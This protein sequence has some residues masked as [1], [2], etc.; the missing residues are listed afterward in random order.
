[1][2][3]Y[4]R[5]RGAAVRP[6]TFGDS[7]GVAVAL[8]GRTGGCSMQSESQLEA[9]LG[10]STDPARL[11]GFPSLAL[12]GQ[13]VVPYADRTAP[14]RAT[15]S[16]FAEL[17]DDPATD[18]SELASLAMLREALDSLVTLIERVAPFDL[19]ACWSTPIV[20]SGGRVLGTFAMYYDEPKEPTPA[21]IQLT[22]TAT[23][24]AKN[25]IK[26]ARATTK[27]HAR[28]DAAERLAVALQESET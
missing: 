27:L 4:D 16:F 11:A 21:D 25:V 24:L 15:G 13:H 18:D 8:L 6:P 26:R 28:T 5:E 19:V 23:L 7:S 22:E 10:S 17:G 2:R 12:T 3:P 9:R 14:R 20:D 1:T